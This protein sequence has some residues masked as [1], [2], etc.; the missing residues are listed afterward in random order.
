MNIN[1]Y[2]NRFYNLLESKLGNVKPLIC[3]I[4]IGEDKI[5]LSQT[6]LSPEKMKELKD[7]NKTN[8]DPYLP[9]VKVKKVSDI[10]GNQFKDAGLIS[11][12]EYGITFE[13]ITKNVYKVNF[14]NEFI[15]KYF[16]LPT[17]QV[18]D[19]QL[20]PYGDEHGNKDVPMNADKYVNTISGPIAMEYSIEDS[21]NNI[22][23]N[24]EG[25]PT[26]RIHFP[27]GVPRSLR[28]SGIGYIIYESFI[29]YLGW[30]SSQ[31]NASSLAQV[32]W[33]KLAEDPDFYSFVIE[34][35]NDTSVFTISKKSDLKPDNIVN[36]I[37]YHFKGGGNVKLT[38]GDD[39]KNDYPNLVVASENPINARFNLFFDALK[40]HL[41]YLISLKG[42]VSFGFTDGFY[43]GMLRKTNEVMDILD[44]ED[45]PYPLYRSKYDEVKSLFDK[46]VDLYYIS[47]SVSF[48]S[49][50]LGISKNAP[51]W[52]RKGN[53]GQEKVLDSTTLSDEKK[54]TDGSLYVENFESALNSAATFFNYFFAR[55]VD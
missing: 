30:G 42:N 23:I 25:H 50:D 24:T 47:S 32:I 9:S 45:Y 20:G 26:N 7:T 8:P 12:N 10:K 39:L 51:K 31:P 5:D 35:N 28:G 53:D 40:Y 18:Y 27:S 46:V 22:N 36:S 19:G 1:E 13:E 41:D 44:S 49:D 43:N 17:S 11:G 38:L 2:R 52:K 33:S 14:P 48:E 4:E 6:Y 37:L 29:K 55:Y 15:Q 16:S 3:E 54:W 34:M 21:L